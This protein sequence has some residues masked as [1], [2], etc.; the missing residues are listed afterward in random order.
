MEHLEVPLEATP[1]QPK[2]SKFICLQIMVLEYTGQRLNELLACG[3]ISRT[4]L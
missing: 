2:H 3:D 4:T 1:C